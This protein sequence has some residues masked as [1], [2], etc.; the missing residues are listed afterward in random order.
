MKRKSI[1]RGKENENGAVMVM[2]A[3]LISVLLCFTALVI[4][5]GLSYHRRSMLQTA[6][7][8]AALAIASSV[9]NINDFNPVKYNGQGAEIMKEAQKYYE[10]NNI[11]VFKY[12]RGN[13][14]ETNIKVYSLA[15]KA[16][17]LNNIQDNT[18]YIFYDTVEATDGESG[19]RYIEVVAKLKQ[20]AIFGNVLEQMS[21]YNL[22]VDSAA[23]CEIVK[24]GN[25]DALNYQILVLN[26]EAD[27]NITGPIE[28]T[29]LKTFLNI[30]ENVTNAGLD[31]LQNRTH[32]I[33]E[34]LMGGK[35]RVKCPACSYEAQEI[36][37]VAEASDGSKTYICPNCSTECTVDDT[38]KV[39]MSLTTSAA[40]LNGFVHSNG[41]ARI[42][43]DTFRMRSYLEENVTP[44]DDLIDYTDDFYTYYKNGI[45]FSNRPILEISGDESR[46]KIKERE[47]ANGGTQD[48]FFLGDPITKVIDG[49]E[50]SVYRTIYKRADQAKPWDASRIKKQLLYGTDEIEDPGFIN[51]VHKRYIDL[52]KNGGN[53]NV[54]AVTKQ[55]SGSSYLVDFEGTSED[56]LVWVF[57]TSTSVLTISGNTTMQ[58]YTQSGVTVAPWSEYA[59]Q[60]KYVV[61][62]DGVK[63][64]GKYA[65]YNCTAM[66]SV[67]IPDTVS[68]VG[69]SAFKGCKS[70][71]QVVLG[72]GVKKLDTYAFMQSGL[73]EIYMPSVLTKIGTSVFTSAPLK[74]IYGVAG[75]YAETYAKSR[76]LTFKA[77][78]LSL[79][80][81]ASSIETP[82]YTQI[83]NGLSLLNKI[84]LGNDKA[85]P[86]V[87]DSFDS[88][89]KFDFDVDGKADSIKQ[90]LSGATTVKDIIAAKR[91]KLDSTGTKEDIRIGIDNIVAGVTGVEHSIND[92]PDNYT[93]EQFK[94]Y[95][96]IDIPS[97]VSKTST[98]L[99]TNL[100]SFEKSLQQNSKLDGGVDKTVSKYYTTVNSSILSKV[101]PSDS[102]LR[103]SVEVKAKGFADSCGYDSSSVNL[104]NSI[105]AKDSNVATRIIS[106]KV[107]GFGSAGLQNLNNVSFKDDGYCTYK[108]N[109]NGWYRGVNC[110][111]GDNVVYSGTNLANN[112]CGIII[113]S[114][115][116]V[117][118]NGYVRSGKKTSA[119]QSTFTKIVLNA[120]T[121][122]DPTVLYAGGSQSINGATVSSRGDIY[123]YPHSRL[124]VHG[125]ILLEEGSLHMWD[126]TM[127][128]CDG[129]IYVKGSGYGIIEAS[130]A[131]NCSIICSGDIIIEGNS[132]NSNNGIG[133][134]SAMI[135]GGSFSGGKADFYCKGTVLC[136]GNFTSGILYNTGMITTG[137]TINSTGKIENSADCIIIS[138][139]GNIKSDKNGI[140]NNGIM[141]TKTGSVIAS[142]GAVTNNSSAYLSSGKNLEIGATSNFYN[143][144]CIG[145]MLS[146]SNE[147]NVYGIF[148]VDGLAKNSDGSEASDELTASYIDGV[149]TNCVNVMNAAQVYI[150]GRVN[151]TGNGFVLN[152]SDASNAARVYIDGGLA[153][154]TGWALNTTTYL[155]LTTGTQLYIKGNVHFGSKDST[156]MNIDASS[157]LYISGN[158]SSDTNCPVPQGA[159]VHVGSLTMNSTLNVGVAEI[160]E[161]IANHLKGALWCEGDVTVNNAV[162]LYGLAF[163]EGKLT[164]NGLITVD[165]YTRSYFGNGIQATKINLWDYGY[166]FVKGD[167]VTTSSETN[168]IWYAENASAN[169]IFCDG[170]VTSAG[171][172]SVYD[173][174]ILLI[175]EQL[176]V[177]NGGI[178]VYTAATLFARDGITFNAATST[179]GNTFYTDGDIVS[180]YSSKS[181]INS[182]NEIYVNYRNLVNCKVNVTVLQP[183]TSTE[184]YN[185][186]LAITGDLYLGEAGKTLTIHKGVSIVTQGY[187]IYLT[188]DVVN[189]GTIKCLE[190]NILG[191]GGNIYVYDA[192]NKDYCSLTN[193][194]IIYAEGELAVKG[195]NHAK[196]GLVW[197]HAGI[198]IK[199]GN[200]KNHN[201][202]I[203]A[204]GA[205]TCYAAIDNFGK[206][207][208]GSDVETT[209]IYNAKTFSGG[210]NSTGVGF[211]SENNSVFMT[212]GCVNTNNGNDERTSIVVR[213]N[214]IF[215]VNGN[216]KTSRNFILGNAFMQGGTKSEEGP[217]QYKYMSGSTYTGL[218]NGIAGYILSTDVTQP[219]RL[220]VSSSTGTVGA[221]E[222]SYID[223]DGKVFDEDGK[224]LNA[225]DLIDQYVIYSDCANGKDGNNIRD[226]GL[227]F[228]N[229]TLT[230]GLDSKNY[231]QPYGKSVLY[232]GGSQA[233]GKYLN[234]DYAIHTH[235][236]FTFPYSRVYCGGNLYATGGNSDGIALNEWF[237]TQ[238]Y[239][240]GNATFNGTVKMRD[241]TRSIING[242]VK[243]TDYAEIGKSPSGDDE[244]VDGNNLCFVQCDG[245]FNANGYIKIYARATL[246]ANGN[247]TTNPSLLK[248]SY[249]TLRH[250]AE[251]RA[252]ENITCTQA[253]IG[254]CSTV[255][256]G[257]NFRATLST[258]KIRDNCEIS[259][260]GNGS[261]NL[262]ALSYIELGKH[263]DEEYKYRTWE[264]NKAANT[265]TDYESPD[266]NT[267]A[268]SSDE[269]SIGSDDESHIRITCPKCGTQGT[270]AGGQFSSTIVEDRDTYTCAYCSEVFDDTADAFDDDGAIGGAIY[271]NGTIKS[272]TSYLKIFANTKAYATKSIRSLSYITLRHHAGLYVTTGSPDANGIM[273]DCDENGRLLDTN[274]NVVENF[275]VDLDTASPEYSNIYY[276]A[277]VPVANGGVE[278]IKL[279]GFN[280]EVDDSESYD[281]DKSKGSIYQENLYYYNSDGSKD[282][283]AEDVEVEVDGEITT[284]T[285]YYG[286]Q[287]GVL[288]L[289]EGTDLSGTK[290][291]DAVI[292]VFVANGSITSYGDLSVN[293][294]AN[295][296]ATGN[297]IPYGKCY[298]GSK[299]VVYA[300]KDF[301]STKNISI[302]SLIQGNSVCGFELNHGAVYAGGDFKVYGCSDIEGGTINSVG[303]IL[304]SSIYTNYVY[305][306]NNIYTNPKDV[307]LFICSENGNIKFN[308]IYSTTGGIT[309][310]PNGKI[311]ANGVYFEH[312]GSFIGFDININS[313]YINLHRAANLETLDLGWNKAGNVYL[314][315]PVNSL[316]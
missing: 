219:G 199:N 126:D 98:I 231:V 235:H 71:K 13:V 285:Y 73:Q 100:I 264:Q 43:I 182:S 2:V 238:L 315:E 106:E 19:Y 96:D 283:Y 123:M 300:E 176:T 36:Y 49:E 111:D 3:I 312:Y 141:V 256:A 246:N 191:K 247:V 93:E 307:D 156:S 313:F 136:N 38:N 124:I 12:V 122:E 179:T 92:L 68:S 262:S 251:L 305:D 224:V 306:G 143:W 195:T 164:A 165:D 281:A 22:L 54:G 39:S 146:G 284:V 287:N 28:N 254:S 301:R 21:A 174:G 69:N 302:S 85:L 148:C 234:P 180:N 221:G 184:I 267:G 175:D 255:Y 242:S 133:N 220:K 259:V 207:Y 155:R 52:S 226:F 120:G 44:D 278:E 1:F 183:N 314:C 252:A 153:S 296:Y 118:V 202:Q 127:I 192:D 131:S 229:G 200:A 78:K 65:F 42:D 18:C 84:D 282:Y 186:I 230:T 225:S 167:I 147:V 232:V 83:V 46:L 216:V 316:N 27:F 188:G 30:F 168:S 15:K 35:T 87:Y 90:V 8:S 31:F 63:S 72:N 134:A 158:L 277:T 172:L 266:G 275:Y 309:Y 272:T 130:G 61:I 109:S 47:V 190:G 203:Y 178:I 299:A 177:Q 227:A 88:Y 193:Y 10:Q 149:S 89:Y 159:L 116:D 20:R 249:L 79:D 173:E 137:G 196:N 290:A 171:S 261:G 55:T 258:M 217:Q 76:S 138:E 228:I 310:A 56:G 113:H 237:Y 208:A 9:A 223:I 80:A 154:D 81:D 57:N 139:G 260:G 60:I 291:S 189:N 145:G 23:K 265:N 128:I 59:G 311:E 140:T 95:F 222:V 74:T 280:V 41:G 218:D 209:T 263:E 215:F 45:K 169:L 194:G 82:K 162:N 117:S 102:T 29:N 214:A 198:S 26:P 91:N 289:G 115:S 157:Y 4:D 64:I 239:I 16:T 99:K 270:V 201:S 107:V 308:S 105:L 108:R 253:D 181:T 244:A 248:K 110:S 75:S 48:I 51:Y 151:C 5:S 97:A 295:L 213:S 7:D 243:A 104:Y 37:F 161:S 119:G 298:I 14:N 86:N 204:D 245:D 11:K 40:V 292:N 288:T 271:V 304:F 67:D 250:H 166:L 17:V 144:V 187:D 50:K 58:D 33:S 257:K 142:G 274:G 114:R 94:S 163:I 160:E 211:D 286:I 77:E 150:R 121:A 206:F 152:S 185:D 241:A 197:Y 294:Y 129:N 240:N 212:D 273:F 210:Q 125:N 303:N 205:V 135:A 34:W 24:G 53:T 62:N 268:G 66:V 103:N 233:N 236:V 293:A 269:S 170:S 132:T 276:K 70:L 279:Y 6:S 297:I 32:F 101:Q 112:D 25:P